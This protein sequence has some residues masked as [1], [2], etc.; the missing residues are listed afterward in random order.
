MRQLVGI[1]GIP[2]DILNTEA[3]LARM[4]QFVADRRFH[5]VV[6]VNTDFVTN[7]L[8]DPELQTILRNAD[9]AT[10]DGMPIV[11]ASRLLGAPLPERVT[12]ADIVPLMAERAVRH[13]WRLY[14][15]GARPETARLACMRLQADYPGIQIVGCMSP[16]TATLE[17]MEDAATLGDIERARPDILLVAFGS[18]KQE[19][20]IY[21]HRDRLRH[22][23]ICMGVGGTFDF[24]ASQARR[25]P[26]WMQKRG[27]E[28][29]FRLL[30]EPTRLWKRYTRDFYRFGLG[31]MKQVRA[32]R[33][34]RPAGHFGMELTRH[35]D[36]TL[37][38]LHGDLNAA[39]LASVEPTVRDALA[40]P[41]N[42]VLDMHDLASVDGAAVGSLIALQGYAVS[43]DRSIRLASVASPIDA[44]LHSS[45]LFDGLYTADLSVTQ[46]LSPDLGP[47]SSR[48]RTLVL[49]KER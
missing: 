19:K 31:L 22:V 47:S 16:Q 13:G 1:L 5:Q 45:R 21:R 27:L 32:M 28:W 37:L 3:V 43:Q 15:L 2:I 49:P 23:P 6:T 30:H 11:W 35:H 39:S 25:A 14:L 12:G 42:V 8:T 38:T 40:L 36:R 10:P 17:A 41:S 44:F 18:P 29:L 24:L 33:R 20:W 34:C 7:A 46:A 48:V 26:V 9:L 4:E